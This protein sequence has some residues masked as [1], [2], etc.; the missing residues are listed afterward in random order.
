MGASDDVVIRAG[1]D[2]TGVDKGAANID[3]TLGGLGKA[4]GVA[5]AAIAAGAVA[6]GAALAKSVATAAAFEQSMANVASVTGGGADAIERLSAV[7]REAGASTIFSASAAGDA[8]YYLASAGYDTGEIAAS[9]GD[10]LQMAAAGGMD[11]AYS[12]QILTS[13]LAQFKLEASDSAR[14]SNVL[15]AAAS[16][17]NTTIGQLGAGMGYVGPVAASLGWEIEE[18]TAALGLL[19]NAGLKGERGGTALRG[20]LS[21]LMKPSTA[22]TAALSEMGIEIADMDPA[23]H[24]LVEMI[25][26]LE[27]G[28]MTAAQAVAIF[29]QEAGPSM[30]ALVSQGSEALGEMESKITGT[31]KAAEMA[32][33]QTATLQG[34]M[35]MLSS[36]LEEAQIS[37][38]NEFLPFLTEGVKGATE[39]V[40]LLSSNFDTLS[41]AARN[42]GGSIKESF[43]DVFGSRTGPTEEDAVAWYTPF[44]E[45]IHKTA[46]DLKVGDTWYGSQG[47]LDAAR[48]AGELSGETYTQASLDLIKSKAGILEKAETKRVSMWDVLGKDYTMEQLNTTVDIAVETTDAEKKVSGFIDKISKMQQKTDDGKWIS[49]DDATLQASATKIVEMYADIG[50]AA[51]DIADPM[52]EAWKAGLISNE[53]YG[54]AVANTASITKEFADEAVPALEKIGEAFSSGDIAQIEEAQKLLEQLDSTSITLGD[55]FEKLA[56]PLQ[57]AFVDGTL[58]AAEFNDVLNDMAQAGPRISE[59][60]ADTLSSIGENMDP[61][62]LDTMWDVIAEGAK[63]KGPETASIIA[64]AI[65]KAGD[66]AAEGFGDRFLDELETNLGVDAEEAIKAPLVDAAESAGEGAGDAFNKGLKEALRTGQPQTLAEL[67]YL[68]SFRIVG[69]DENAGEKGSS[70]FT[71]GGVEYTY[72]WDTSGRQNDFGLYAD[73]KKI[74]SIMKIAGLASPKDLLKD[75]GI[76]GPLPGTADW[77]DMMG[78]E[79]A[80]SEKGFTASDTTSE[81][82]YAMAVTLR[83]EPVL[84][85]EAINQTLVDQLAEEYEALQRI[86]DEQAEE[87]AL[88]IVFGMDKYVL[89]EMEELG[90]A[91]IDAFSNGLTYGEAADLLER[92]AFLDDFRD[93]NKDIWADIGDESAD[94]LIDAL[95]A[96]DWEA[97]GALIGSQVGKTM[98]A[99]LSAYGGTAISSLLPEA[100]VGE[101]TQSLLKGTPLFDKEVANFPVWRDAVWTEERG[102]YWTEVDAAIKQGLVD[103]EETQTIAKDIYALYAVNPHLFY[104]SEKDTFDAYGTSARTYADS[105]SLVNFEVAKHAASTK[106]AAD[107]TKDYGDEMDNLTKCMGD[108]CEVMSKFSQWQEDPSNDLFYKSAITNTTSYVERIKA[109]AKEGLASETQILYAAQKE[110]EQDALDQLQY[111][112]LG[113]IRSGSKLEQELWIDADTS[114]AETAIGNVETDIE[115]TR[116]MPLDIDTSSAMSA[117]QDIDAAAAAPVVK[118]VYLMAISGG[119]GGGAIGAIENWS[120]V[121]GLSPGITKSQGWGTDAWLPSLQSGGIASYPMTANI[122]DASTPEVVAPL[123]DLMPMIQSAV[124][125]AGGGNT[126]IYADITVNESGNAEETARAVVKEFEK[127]SSRSI[128]SGGRR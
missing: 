53:E 87:H 97:V 126:I 117:I 37:V 9:L 46:Q 22:A 84:D 85:Q 73:G 108:A 94:A 119:S 15:S 20:A 80:R 12:S 99:A 10:T 28:S 121:E 102:T 128:R 83:L 64:D 27:K 40:K 4:A 6:A 13:T 69:Y 48:N 79:V 113:V 63:I 70:Q 118:P 120:Y 43:T 116:T 67:Q 23:T 58:S 31:S 76:D 35:K 114:L 107:A 75:A 68:N 24:S 21:A 56:G 103:A 41:D 59:G 29:G 81:E 74:A 115:T 122:G 18:T 110:R 14:V 51:V 45:G 65:E 71:S 8:M 54:E 100:S 66:P 62:Q 36:A 105:L 55:N 33:T 91:A 5:F 16:A 34:A 52:A 78:A 95:L 57:A 32:A 30:L 17:T 106:D 11:L 98:E 3:R 92:A 124:E 39:A 77:Y 2:T 50:D 82:Y 25:G 47:D 123:G 49:L 104:E 90:E 96:G 86:C 26:S 72:R 1:M 127:T 61:H 88:D 44:T 125:N 101:L 93:N 42:A 89:S 7:A 112:E 19:A 38:G 109:L 111:D 60:L